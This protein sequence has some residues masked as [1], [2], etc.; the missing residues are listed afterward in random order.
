MKTDIVPIRGY[1]LHLTHYSPRWYMRKR[2]ERPI[3]IK[4]ALEI[5]DSA[6]KAGFNVLIIECEDGLIYKSHPELRRRYSIPRALL[7]KLLNYAR[8][9]K[10]EVVPKLN[11]S[12]SI[13]HKHDYWLRP[14]TKLPDGERYWKIAFELID[15][16]IGLF[17]SER[18]FHI[19]MDEDDSRTHDE[20]I[21]AVIRFRDGL[22]KRGLR[23]LMWNDTAFGRTR[24]WHT[25][26]S[27]AAEKRIPKDIVQVVWDYK[28]IKPEILR[29]ITNEGFEVWVA[30]NQNPMH[31]LRWKKA[32]LKYGGKGLIMTTWL[33]CRPRNRY[34]MLNLIQT[35]GPVYSAR[36]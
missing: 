30:P 24:P 34:Y 12:R 32:I 2:R 13:Y 8:K 1:L 23:A 6:A 4:L 5:I 21:K 14:H 18:F 10:L 35:L 33:P 28:H 26:K 11:F 9:R 27:L 36:V 7:K 20:Y 3:D 16:L 25:R 22:K 19:G 29:R 17:R 31:V 15:E